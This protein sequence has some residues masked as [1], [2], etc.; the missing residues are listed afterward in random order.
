MKSKE[1]ILWGNINARTNP[2]SAES[3]RFPKY[4]GTCNLFKSFE[5]FSWWCY[6]SEGFGLLD[7]NGN[8]YHLDKDLATLSGDIEFKAYGPHCVFLPTKLNSV[9]RTSYSKSSHM[10]GTTSY[11]DG[12]FRMQYTSI[13]GVKHHGGIFNTELEAHKAWNGIQSEVFN[14]ASEYAL[15][16]GLIKAARMFK[17]AATRFKEFK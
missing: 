12:R 9:V 10:P 17:Q 11:K 1:R 3:K 2:E 16:L 7:S 8:S 6:V 13:D 14:D 15:R 5:E 4:V